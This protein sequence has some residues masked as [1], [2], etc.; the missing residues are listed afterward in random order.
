MK[1]TEKSCIELNSNIENTIDSVITILTETKNN[2]QTADEFE[3]AFNLLT[4]KSQL[5]RLLDDMTSI[6]E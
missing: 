4:A 6:S 5:S 3:T 1:F 2:M